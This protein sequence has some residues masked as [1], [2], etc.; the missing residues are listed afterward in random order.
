MGIK[1]DFPKK[2]IVQKNRGSPLSNSAK[3]FFKCLAKHKGNHFEKIVFQEKFFQ[4]LRLE[5]VFPSRMEAF[6][7]ENGEEWKI[8]SRAVLKKT[9]NGFGV[10]PKNKKG[11]FSGQSVAAKWR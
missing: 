7:S 9:W 6:Q 4:E 1:Q 3:R 8:E 11:S 2:H 10:Y 5:K